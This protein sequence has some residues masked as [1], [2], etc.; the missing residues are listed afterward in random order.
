M[1]Y[2]DGA[3]VAGSSYIL[4]TTSWQSIFFV[5]RIPEMPAEFADDNLSGKFPK[6]SVKFEITITCDTADNFYINTITS[7]EGYYDTETTISSD[8]AAP[9]WK[10]EKAS[11]KYPST[12][13]FGSYPTSP[14][15]RYG[16]CQ[17]KFKKGTEATTV[18]RMIAARIK[19]VWDDTYS[20]VLELR[21]TGAV[22]PRVYGP[23][24][25]IS[26]W[27]IKNLL[28]ASYNVMLYYAYPWYSIPLIG[29][30]PS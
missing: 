30:V 12:I 10:N 11:D 27:H 6:H 20:G 1:A 19:T 8:V 23:D 3:T 14:K 16:I 26:A 9:T 24:Y 28:M 21:D 13:I 29:P 2:P 15:P 5:H 7:K 4:A 25:P 17:I 18:A 22:A